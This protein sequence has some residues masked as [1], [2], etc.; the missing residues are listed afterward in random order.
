MSELG[1]G[2]V[3]GADA[4][5]LLCRFKKVHGLW[6]VWLPKYGLITSRLAAAPSHGGEPR[7]WVRTF[8]G[9]KAFFESNYDCSSLP[10]SLGLHPRSEA[11]V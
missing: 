4:W 2:P 7:P 6:E 11:A 10:P 1:T 9:D 8:P 3:F 5:H